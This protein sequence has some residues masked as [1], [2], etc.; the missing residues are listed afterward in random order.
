[1]LQNDLAHGWG[2]DFALRRCVEPAH[3]K[4]GVVDSQWIIHQTFSLAWEPGASGRM[5][6]HHGKGPAQ[7]SPAQHSTAQPRTA[8]PS[9]VPPRPVPP[10]PSRPDNTYPGRD[11]PGMGFNSNSI[12]GMGMPRPAPPRV[13]DG[14]G[15]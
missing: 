6:R 5:G 1:M 13:W 15:K 10:A 8:Q 4:I 3:E 14:F 7:P 11:G 2:L 9:P 12:T